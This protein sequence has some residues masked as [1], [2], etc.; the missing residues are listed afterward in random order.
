MEKGS[1][2]I[3][4][5]HNMG[6][7]KKLKLFISYSHKDESSQSFIEQFKTH[8]A[9]LKTDG[10]IE[11]W[12]DRIIL[13]RRRL[14]YGNYNNLED[15]EVICLFISANFLASRMLSEEKQLKH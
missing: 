5:V 14:S 1:N 11:D 3:K 7:N 4:V 12:Y 6:Q 15:A 13:S 9:P 2:V 10:L 8:I